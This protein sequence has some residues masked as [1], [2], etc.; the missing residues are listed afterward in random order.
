MANQNPGIRRAAKDVLLGEGN[1]VDRITAWAKA[2]GAELAVI[3]P[4]APLGQGLADALEA[5]GVPT[6]GPSR[7]AARIETDKEFARD[8]VRDHKI[9]GLVDYWAFADLRAFE[10]GRAS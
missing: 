8:L 7:N 10:I 4:E 9:P 5:A 6:V 2:G 1:A 3:G